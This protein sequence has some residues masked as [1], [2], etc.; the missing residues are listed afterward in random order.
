MRFFTSGELNLMV[1]RTAFFLALFFGLG[2]LEAVSQDI[3]TTTYRSDYSGRCSSSIRFTES[4]PARYWCR[5]PNGRA[6]RIPM[7]AANVQAL[8]R[9]S[10]CTLEALTR[11]DDDSPCGFPGGL[12]LWEG[13]ARGDIEIS[14]AGSSFGDPLTEPEEIFVA[15]QLEWDG[16]FP[17][18]NNFFS[19]EYG[20]APRALR[21]IAVRLAGT[22]SGATRTPED[23]RI[24]I[25]TSGYIKLL[26]A[27]K[28]ENATWFAEGEAML[29]GGGRMYYLRLGRETT[30]PEGEYEFLSNGF[31]PEVSNASGSGFLEV[32][33]EYETGP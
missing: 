16:V 24:R 3:S 17:D 21:A 27:R 1:T 23:T 30:V 19:L 25:G 28:S 7:D 26:A 6:I 31:L 10:V 20:N 8:T 18:D 4:P 13:K 15:V 9:V 5:V 22:P 14:H 2:S 11:R 33:A 29:V 12:L 32:E